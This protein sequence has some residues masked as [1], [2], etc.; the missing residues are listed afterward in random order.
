MA[1]SA[2]VRVREGELAPGECPYRLDAESLNPVPGRIMQ[3]P[4]AR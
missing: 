4:A 3:I 2:V 1:D